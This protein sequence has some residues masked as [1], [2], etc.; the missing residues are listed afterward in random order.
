M[1]KLI[2]FM[3]SGQGSHYYQ[4]GKELY[5]KHRQF[6]KWMLELDVIATEIFGKSIVETLYNPSKRPA[7]VFD[8]ALETSPAIIMVEYAL[9][10][11]LMESGIQPDY[12]LGTSLGEITSGILA[13]AVDFR[14]MLEKVK[15]CLSLCER[16]CEKGKMI[17]VLKSSGAFKSSPELY[18]NSELAAVNFDS[19]FII[20]CKMKISRK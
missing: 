19:H 10:M 7:D 3:F 5:Q 15:E 14:N 17:G 4:M 18:Q 16:Y 11:V 2:V 20:S 1:A 9:A 8:K 12:L 13:E 6:K